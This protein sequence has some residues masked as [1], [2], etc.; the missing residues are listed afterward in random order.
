MLGRH[1]TLVASN[2]TLAE[3]I[4][5][6]LSNQQNC[7]IARSD[8]KH[9]RRQIA[10]HANG[11]LL[12]VA[13]A[14]GDV[15]A[16]VEMVRECHLRRCTFTIAIIKTRSLANSTA[17]TCLEQF[18]TDWFH[19]P[20]EA[21]GLSDFLRTSDEAELQEEST[22]AVIASSLR[23]LTPSLKDLAGRLAIAA[24]HDVTVLLSGETGTGKT[25]LA[26]LLHRHSSRRQHPFLIVPCGAQPSELFASTLFGHV[27]GAFTGANQTQPG[28]FA[29]A[30]KGTILLD[31]VDTLESS[32]QAAL[33]RVI[34]T[35]EYEMVGDHRTLKS[36]ARLIVATNSNLEAAV[37]R[38][39]FRQDLFYRLNVMAFHL[40]PLR[41]R[42]ADITQLARHFA[43]QFG[44][45]H[46]KSIVD[47]SPGALQSLAGFAWPGNVR[48]LENAVQEAVLVCEGEELIECDL[49]NAVRRSAAGTPAGHAIAENELNGNA[50]GSGSGAI[51]SLSRSRGEY[52][53]ALIQ[54]TLEAHQSNRSAAARA[55]GISRVTLHKK[56][57]QYDLRGL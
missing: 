38:R 4:Q 31:E 51:A 50:N 34:E 37:D 21:D 5:A 9:L 16:V 54:Q 25:F 28:K 23:A 10:W 3:Q 26:R 53:R 15:E 19:W 47:I 6:Y 56:I 27:K 48:Q 14:E 55:L 41:E 12:L 7:T 40:P 36:E 13:D 57:N 52:E 39:E 1:P 24:M 2:Q 18:V 42:S 8:Y 17:L 46:G 33:L 20:E 44:V 22:T 29:S 30:G 43:A 45:K 35:G 11:P 32:Q 49:P